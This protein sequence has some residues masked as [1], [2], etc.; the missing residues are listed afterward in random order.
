MLNFSLDNQDIRENGQ[1]NADRET[2]N[3]TKKRR[4]NPESWKQNVRR[5]KR[6]HGEE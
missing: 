5:K 6:Q 2:L 4:R 3:L 1:D